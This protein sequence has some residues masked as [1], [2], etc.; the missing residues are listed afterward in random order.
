MEEITAQDILDLLPIVAD[1][2]WQIDST[3]F[4]RDTSWSCPICALLNETHGRGEKVAAGNAWE[5]VG[6]RDDAGMKS[7]VGAADNE[8][9][10]LRPDLMRALGMI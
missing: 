5:G 8:D 10:P 4:I 2:G 1:R 6:F 7:I 3:G 9:H